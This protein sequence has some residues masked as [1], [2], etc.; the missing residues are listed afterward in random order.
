MGGGWQVF[1]G[2]RSAAS[3][4]ARS[5]SG[6][7]GEVWETT[8]AARNVVSPARTL[9]NVRESFANAAGGNASGRAST[10]PFVGSRFAGAAPLGNRA[11]AGSQFSNNFAGSGFR[12]RGWYGNSFYGYRGGFGG[13]C[14][15]CGLGF[16]YGWGPGWGFGFG[17]PWYGFGGLY[18]SDPWW[19]WPGYGYYGNPI[20]YLYGGPYSGYYSD[21]YI[22]PTAQVNDGN[23]P[24][25]Q[26]PQSYSDSNSPPAAPSADQDAPNQGSTQSSV[27]ATAAVPILL[28]MKDGSVYAARDYWISN[29]QLQYVLLSGTSG[30]IDAD[31]LDMQ[32]SIVENARSG[33]TFTLKNQ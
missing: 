12:G 28:Y 27:A 2:N 20:G 25:A 9:S 29:G 32:R 7:G 13:R 4:V 1:G 11:V 18:W 5:F 3:G 19:G 33:V 15:N 26:Y 22:D 8:P 17:W 16:G 14:W 30:A 31:R 10:S 6:Q 21:P 24:N 23:D